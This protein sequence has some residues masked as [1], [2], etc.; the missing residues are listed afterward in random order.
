[1]QVQAQRG[2]STSVYADALK[3]PS[4]GG[5]QGGEGLADPAVLGFLEV[6]GQDALLVLQLLHQTVI[7]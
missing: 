7:T 6:I 4:A 5:A 3:A 2:R 1:M